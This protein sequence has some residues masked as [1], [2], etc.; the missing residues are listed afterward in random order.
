MIHTISWINLVL[1]EPFGQTVAC[2]QEVNQQT[3]PTESQYQHCSDY[4]AHQRDG[5]LEYVNDGDDGENNS[6]DVN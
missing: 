4:L 2:K 5:F 1:F 3:D 6:D